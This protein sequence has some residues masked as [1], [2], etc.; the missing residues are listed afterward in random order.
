MYSSTLDF[1][2]SEAAPLNT[3][4]PARPRALKFRPR[5]TSPQLP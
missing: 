2:H 4:D 5:K 1:I 3:L